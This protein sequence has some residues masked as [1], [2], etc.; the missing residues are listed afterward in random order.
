MKPLTYA[1]HE[2]I[3]MFIIELKARITEPTLLLG[4]DNWIERLRN[5]DLLPPKGK[6]P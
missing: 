2:G 5:P 4:C 3:R 6:T 1:E